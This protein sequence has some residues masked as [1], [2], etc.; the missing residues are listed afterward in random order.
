MTPA[1]LPPWP[2]EPV[3]HGPVILREFGVRDVPMA[4]EASTDPY[5][6]LIGTLSP[7]ASEQEARDWVDRQRGRLA[8]GLGFSFAIAE[9]DT[10]RAVGAVGLWLAGLRQGRATIGYSI[11]PSARGRGL[12]AAALIAVTEPGRAPP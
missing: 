7:N 2:T 8:E 5:I 3:A 6:P 9:A 1:D 12:A 11:I 4:Q 10:G